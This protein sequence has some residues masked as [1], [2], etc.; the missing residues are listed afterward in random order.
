MSM[1]LHVL[2]DR[3]LASID[4]WQRAIDREGFPL[5]LSTETPFDQL[6]GLLPARLRDAP[7]GFEC[8][9]WDAGGD[10]KDYTDT[11]FGRVWTYALAFR[12]LGS[13]LAEME[14]AWMASS[15]YAR[16]TDGVVFDLESGEI[17]TSSRAVEAA[18]GV[19]DQEALIKAAVAG[20]LKKLGLQ[21]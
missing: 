9:H 14:A 16:A 3:R 10:L 13:N 12:W 20:A 17:L 2:S 5:R 8:D 11:D 7:I 19:G 4:D 15:A 18:R 6:K 1:E 21:P